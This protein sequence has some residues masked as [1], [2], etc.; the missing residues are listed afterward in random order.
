MNFSQQPE[1][2]FDSPLMQSVIKI[3]STQ[4]LSE[5]KIYTINEPRSFIK[6]ESKS[7]V[8]VEDVSKTAPTSINQFGYN[9]N[10]N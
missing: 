4:H 10:S 9:F 7:E 6:I 3:M 8:Q 5:Q 1:L 2:C